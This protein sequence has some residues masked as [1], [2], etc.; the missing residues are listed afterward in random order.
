VINCALFL[1]INVKKIF[2][3]WIWIFPLFPIIFP[4]S[5]YE[6]ELLTGNGFPFRILAAT[7][8]FFYL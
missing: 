5:H 7:C 2:P 3:L 8:P 4:F 1:V 6:Y